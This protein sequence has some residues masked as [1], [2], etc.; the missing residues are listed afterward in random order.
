MVRV[1]LVEAR[2]ARAG[3]CL[4]PRTVE[5]IDHSAAIVDQMFLLEQPGRDRHAGAP[6]PEHLREQLMRSIGTG[7]PGH[8]PGSGESSG[9][10]GRPVRGIGHTPPSGQSAPAERRDRRRRPAATPGRRSEPSRTGPRSFAAPSRLPGPMRAEATSQCP[11]PACFRRCPR[12][13]RGRLRDCDFDRP[14]SAVKQNRKW[15]N[16]R[17]EWPRPT[18][19][20]RGRMPAERD[21]TRR[22]FARVRAPRSGRAAD[23]RSRGCV[24]PL[25]SRP[26]GRWED[27]TVVKR[28]ASPYGEW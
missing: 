9:L 15:G 2:I 24:Q 11:M 12:C 3:G 25:P 14:A 23:S 8:D 5:N 21:R 20:A 10:D 7:S 6:D 19:T 27:P 17:G 13:P 22:Q 1:N 16:R 18:R 28:S 4:E 26:L